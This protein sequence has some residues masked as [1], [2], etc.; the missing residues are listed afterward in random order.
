MDNLTIGPPVVTSLR[1]HSEE[2]FLDCHLMVSEP[3]KWVQARIKLSQWH[4][5]GVLVRN[6]RGVVALRLVP[7]YYLCRHPSL[8]S[9][10]PEEL[11]NYSL[12][13]HWRC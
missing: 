2:A 9:S 3:A 10:Q 13:H 5:Y 6:G 12:R 1:K 11:H 8:M 4:L 7:A